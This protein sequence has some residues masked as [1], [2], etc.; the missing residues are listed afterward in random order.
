MF[1]ST[2][3]KFRNNYLCSN[4]SFNIN[5]FLRYIL[6]QFQDIQRMFARTIYGTD[7]PK[8]KQTKKKPK[9]LTHFTFLKSTNSLKFEKQLKFY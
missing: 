7:R 4:D 3:N 1:K 2:V 9:L 5:Y 8:G 6:Q